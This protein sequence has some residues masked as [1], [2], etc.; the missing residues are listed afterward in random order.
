MTIELT[1]AQHERLVELL[2]EVA[3][4]YGHEAAALLAHPK[5]RELGLTRL[6]QMQTAEELFALLAK[7]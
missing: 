1:H 6:G 5:A 4:Q 2:A 3:I 7:C